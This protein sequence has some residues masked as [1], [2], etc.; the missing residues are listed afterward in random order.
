M[1]DLPTHI[2]VNLDDCWL[3]AGT[4]DDHGYGR[5]YRWSKEKQHM[6]TV[7]AHQVMYENTV[8]KIPEGLELNHLCEVPLCIN[9]EHLE[10]VTHKQNM[11]YS[12]PF[13][14]NRC[15]RG[16]ELTEDNVRTW[17][18]KNTLHRRCRTC[19]RMMARR[20]YHKKRSAER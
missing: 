11:W 20:N 19:D 16:H 13:G 15:K 8:G 7:L 18:I 2:K 9:P 14:D 6:G 17:Y 4:I 10:A 1:K 5:V 3:Y 12:Q